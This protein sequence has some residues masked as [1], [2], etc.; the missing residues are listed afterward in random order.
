MFKALIGDIFASDVQTLCNTVNCVGV[1]GKGVALEFKKRFPH[2]ARDYAARCVRK[3]V[4]LGEPY[5]YADETR[6]RILN[7]PTKGH[8][9]SS[10]RL[11]DIERGLDYLAI[12]VAEWGI[13][14]LALPPLGCGNGGLAWSEVG[15]LIYAKLHKLPIDVEVYAPYG[16]PKS[17]LT[18]EF[19]AAPS[20]LSLTGRGIRPEKPNPSWITLLEVLRELQA[21]PY[22]NPVGRTIF[23]KIA[24]V[25]TE[26]GV[27]TGFDFGKGSYGP[28]SGDMKIALHDFANR[29]W[30]QE[31]QLGKMIAFRV[32]PQYEKDRRRL[33]PDME[34][35]RKKIDK[36]VD[37]FSRIKSTE[38]AEEVATIIYACRWI[39]ARRPEATVTEQGI[40]DYVLD[41]KPSWRSEEKREAVAEAIRNLVVLNWVKAEISEDMIEAA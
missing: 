1:M 30:L 39:K 5:L 33:G 6:V 16:T 27:P 9:R 21:Q 2:M 36:T 23:Q 17:E 8:W 41:W 28:F 29:N 24:Y 22:A 34:L 35:Y 15:P 26:M 18:A 40:L 7:F 10:S 4:R 38:Q 19:L 3:E 32:S 12:H 13:K 14:S 25:L 11:A 37:L 31:A 20:Q